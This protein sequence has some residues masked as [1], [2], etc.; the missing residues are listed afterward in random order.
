MLE[1]VSHGFI[2]HVFAPPDRPDSLV[3]KEEKKQCTR[4]DEQVQPYDSSC[5]VLLTAMV[6]EPIWIAAV[7]AAGRREGVTC[8][9]YYVRDRAGHWHN[10]DGMREEERR[11]RVIQIK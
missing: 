7:E 8:H 2:C 9:Q 6:P 4:V 3:G 10:L 5:A 11:R 1:K